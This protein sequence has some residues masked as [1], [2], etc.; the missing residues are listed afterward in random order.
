MVGDA[1]RERERACEGMMERPT[2]CDIHFPTPL[3]KVLLLERSRHG[4]C[5]QIQNNIS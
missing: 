2:A 1:N 5:D 4:W 3:R